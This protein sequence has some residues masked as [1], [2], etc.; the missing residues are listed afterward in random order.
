MDG[1][2]SQVDPKSIMLNGFFK[3]IWVAYLAQSF[4][5]KRGS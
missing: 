4:A 1:G 2:D 5:R 3:N